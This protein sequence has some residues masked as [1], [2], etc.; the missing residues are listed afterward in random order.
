MS[1][2][3]LRRVPVGV[4]LVSFVASSLLLACTPGARTAS[5]PSVPATASPASSGTDDDPAGR[6]PPASP[7]PS[8]PAA[9]DPHAPVPA[10]GPR[11]AG[12]PDRGARPAADF[13][14]DGYGD[15]A[16]RKEIPVPEDTSGTG[17]GLVQVLYGTPTGLRPNA[18]QQWSRADFGA[19]VESD[20][21][22]RALANGDL[23]GDGYSDLVVGDPGATDEGWER[24]DVRVLYGSSA[25]LTRARTQSWSLDDPAL[26]GRAEVGDGF[27][28]AL[29]VGNFGRSDEDDLAIGAPGRKAAG[30][31]VVL[32][33]GGVGL[34]AAHAQVWSQD[35]SGIPG[36]S[37][38]YDDFGRSLAAGDF[39]GGGYDEL[40]IG[41][42]YDTVAGLEGAGSLYVLR[43]SKAGLTTRGVQHWMAGRG[44]LQGQATGT[45][46][47]GAVFAVGSFT[48]SGHLD[49]AVGRP[50]WNSI[51]TGGAGAVH[52]LYGSAQGLSARGNQLW[53]EYELGTRKIAGDDPPEDS[54][55]FGASLVAA[56]FGHGSTDDLVVGVPEANTVGWS[57][58]AIHVIY[59]TPAGLRSVHSRQISQV[60][61]GIKGYDNDEA[62][63]GAAVAV[64]RPSEP[65]AH[66]TLVV[67]APWYGGRDDDDRS[68]I[69]QLIPGS[70][71]G[72]TAGGDQ[73]W[74]ASAFPQQPVGESFGETFTS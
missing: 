9:A 34:A 29:A 33:G 7:V 65:K 44:G 21:F 25:G 5:E 42:P 13:N 71:G 46:G 55:Q 68:G 14:G 61:P 60:T 36:K 20:A 73:I 48:E 23:D 1:Q 19:P 2:L 24:G 74:K 4:L 10:Q 38:T 57:D 70:A 51:D 16:V 30:A 62:R 56:D 47:F 41:A 72:L 11:P 32:F 17:R 8:R 43:G 49:L 50:A 3:V 45:G 18:S 37:A 6:T 40:V 39:D 63:F 53:T 58:G 66:P 52:V 54:P 67:G 31:A 26:P 15:L 27:G 59:G 12:T 28:A 22:G 64:L 35:S 69:I